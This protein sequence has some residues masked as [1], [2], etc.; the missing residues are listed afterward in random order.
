MTSAMSHRGPNGINHWIGEAAALGQCM[1]HTTPESLEEV[2]PL[3]NEDASL[4]LVMDGWLSNWIE[5]RRE[6]LQQNAQLRTRSDAELALRAYEHWGQEFLLH[7]EGDFAMVIW[8]THRKRAFC[9]RDRMGHKPF[10]YY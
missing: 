3:L 10:H 4:V 5:L 6:L 7:L 9:A 2:Q 8:D 1:L